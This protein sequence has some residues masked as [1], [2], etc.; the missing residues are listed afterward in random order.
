MTS[1][2]KGG[3]RTHYER[4]QEFRDVVRPV[5]DRTAQRQAE[6]VSA[7]LN[8][9]GAAEAGARPL[10]WRQVPLDAW[11]PHRGMRWVGQAES[12][13]Y[14]EAEVA[15][16]LATWA[17]FLRLEPRGDRDGDGSLTFES[18]KDSGF[19]V[20]IWGVIDRERW[21]EKEW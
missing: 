14:G 13:V 18:P 19:R 21:E 5:L 8:A 15:G 7:E 9:W 12:G 10:Q 17:K 1:D 20:E 2:F 11:E 4:G 3:D 16:V 6:A